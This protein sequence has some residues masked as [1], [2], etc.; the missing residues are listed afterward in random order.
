M[1]PPS[2]PS[3]CGVRQTPRWAGRWGKM[4]SE[5]WKRGPERPVRVISLW[6]WFCPE[7]S[8]LFVSLLFSHSVIEPFCLMFCL[9]LIGAFCVVV[10]CGCLILLVSILLVLSFLG[11]KRK[12]WTGT[13]QKQRSGKQPTTGLNI[14]QQ[15]QKQNK[16]D[17]KP[18]RQPKGKSNNWPSPNPKRSHK[19]DTQPRKTSIHGFLGCHKSIQQGMARCYNVCDAQGRPQRPRMGP[20]EENEQKPISTT[21]HQTR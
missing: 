5:A 2:A 21:Q 10:F 13:P 6:P 3:T 17:R 7:F 9:D 4:C 8:L 15:D 1:P 20:S 12:P 19:R 14:E 16:H 18:R 11:G